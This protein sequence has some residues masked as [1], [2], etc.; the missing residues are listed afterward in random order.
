MTDFFSIRTTGGFAH[1]PGMAVDRPTSFDE[2]GQE[3]ADAVVAAVLCSNFFDRPDP[4][5]Q[6]GVRD[7][8]T[9]LISV[10]SGGRHRSLVIPEPIVDATLA[11]L[12]RI[13]RRIRN[14]RPG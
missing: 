12:V 10:R 1:L 7:A 5:V 6:T 9:H 3:D 4:A 2:L 8:R 14:R 11:E 13:L